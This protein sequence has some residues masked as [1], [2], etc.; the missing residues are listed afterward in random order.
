MQ[1][2]VLFGNKAREKLKKGVDL[3]ADSIKITLGPKGRNVIYGSPVGYPILTKDGVTVSR[4]VE[5]KDPTEKMGLL[6]IRQVSQKTAD[7]CGDGTTTAAVLAQAIFTE[8]LKTLSSGNNPILIKKGIDLAVIEAINYIK[9]HVIKD[10]SEEELKRVAI[11]SANN[12]NSIADVVCQAIKKAGSDGVITIEDNYKDASIYIQTVEGMQLNEGLLS[13]YFVTDKEKMETVYKEAYILICDYEINHIQPLMKPIEMILAGEKRPLIIIANNVQGQALETLVVNRIKNGL[14]IVACKAPYFGENRTE[15]LNDLAILTGGRVV[16][17]SSGLNFDKIE[18]SDFGQANVLATKHHTTFTSGN[19]QQV[20]IDARIK[21]LQTSIEN[22]ESDYEKEKLQERLAKLTSGV[23]VIRVG[24]STEVEQKEKKF[25]IED[26]LCASRAALEEG[27]VAGGGLMLLRAGKSLEKMGVVDI[28]SE[29]E[30]I[31][32]KIIC[33]ALQEPIKQIAFNSGIDGSE[34]IANILS[35]TSKPGLSISGANVDIDK[36]IPGQ[37]IE[38]REVNN[39]KWYFI[40]NLNY[41]YDFLTNQYGDL[42]VLGVLDP[43][44]VVR[45]TLENAASVAGALLTCECT[46]CDDNEEDERTLKL[47]T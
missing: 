19:G 40:D 7:D 26:A 10:P 43:F 42:M 36:I 21:V 4:N 24:G 23:A 29:E 6:L 33:K 31:G 9:Q 27:I 25:R 46:I 12:D 41:G 47:R 22:T 20:D 5:N 8:G 44:K 32:W 34:V 14:Q 17:Q 3:I 15:Q 30:K 45:L 28:L 13:P 38:I 18:L 1:K 37:I 16:G 39:Q 2:I 35:G 11:I